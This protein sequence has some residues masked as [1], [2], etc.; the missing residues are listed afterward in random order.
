[1]K[2]CRYCG[3][4]LLDE[5]VMCPR[6]KIMVDG[7]NLKERQKQDNENNDYLEEEIVESSKVKYCTKCGYQLDLKAKICDNCGCKTDDIKNNQ[8]STSSSNNS[9]IRTVAN[10]F[11]IIGAIVR[12]VYI[13]PIL[14]AVPLTIAYFKK[15]NKNEK[16][17]TG[18]K[19]AILLLVSVIG[20]AILLIE[21]DN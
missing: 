19:I 10:I 3:K 1:M 16:I 20:G 14:W 7:S 11:V 21:E 8:S 15:N 18:F 12:C 9:S 6:C 2:Y 5:A 4:E 17:G 13:V